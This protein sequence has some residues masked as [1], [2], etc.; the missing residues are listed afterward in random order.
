MFYAIRKDFFRSSLSWLRLLLLFIVE[1]LYVSI[2]LIVSK[3]RMIELAKRNLQNPAWNLKLLRSNVKCAFFWYFRIVKGV[4]PLFYLLHWKTMRFVGVETFWFFFCCCCWLRLSFDLI[5]SM[6]V[7]LL[8]LTTTNW[9]CE[10]MRCYQF[11]LVFVCVHMLSHSYNQIKWNESTWTLISKDEMLP[12]MGLS[13]PN[14][15]I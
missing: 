10:P 9:T 13:I 2:R 14:S 1:L 6:R 11:N 15:S 8:E 4:K 5:I 3:C 12:K 7:S